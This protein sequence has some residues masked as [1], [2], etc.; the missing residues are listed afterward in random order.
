MDEVN[1]IHYSRNF[2]VVDTLPEVGDILNRETV[3]EIAPVVLDWEQ[4]NDD[5][6]RY[7]YYRI[8]LVDETGEE[9]VNYIA[10]EIPE[11]E[12]TEA[13]AIAARIANA[14]QWNAEDCRALCELAGMVEE[15]EQADGET[16]EK[17]VNAAAYKLGVA[18]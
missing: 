7:E 16:F 10:V 14:D 6:Y 4:G 3:T 17:V 2:E 9:T 15:W 12:P 5:V 1:K 13:E 11:E 8:T 18:I